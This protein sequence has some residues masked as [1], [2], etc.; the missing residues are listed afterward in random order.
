MLLQNAHK[1]GKTDAAIYIKAEEA[2][3][4]ND[5]GLAVVVVD[6]K[7]TVTTSLYDESKI[8]VLDAIESAETGVDMVTEGYTGIKKIKYITRT[9]EGTNTIKCKTND[10]ANEIEIG[11]T[12][13]A[14]TQSL[15]TTTESES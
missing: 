7:S 11:F 13:R 9:S 5:A 10:I 2:H 6:I 15:R 4:D 12:L 14:E 3:V 8:R 1:H